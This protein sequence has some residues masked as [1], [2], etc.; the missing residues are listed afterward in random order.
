MQRGL[1]K[2]QAIDRTPRRS[3]HHGGGIGT[4][5]VACATP[6]AKMTTASNAI[7]IIRRIRLIAGFLV[8]R[9]G[10]GPDG[11]AHMTIVR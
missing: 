5:G 2:C 7:A 4:E 8:F 11:F 9:A 3:G 10:I 6:I 1:H